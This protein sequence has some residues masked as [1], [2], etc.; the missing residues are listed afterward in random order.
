MRTLAAFLVL[1]GTLSATAVAAAHTEPPALWQRTVP[2]PGRPT[3]RVVTDDGRIKIGIWDQKQVGMRVT[4]RGYHIRDNELR[5][6][7]TH[8][9]DQ[10]TLEVKLPRP[11]IR[12]DWG[13]HNRSILVEV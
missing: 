5:V 6:T 4:T 10:V 1:A 3:V 8:M 2:V 12:I 9:S 13:W 7:E 11:R